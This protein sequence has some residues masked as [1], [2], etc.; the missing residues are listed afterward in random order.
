M[1]FSVMQGRQE[2]LRERARKLMADVRKGGIS[3][4]SSSGKIFKSLKLHI[5]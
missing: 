3:P 2:E 5:E 4:P 1:A